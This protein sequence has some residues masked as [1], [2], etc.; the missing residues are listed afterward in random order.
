MDHLRMTRSTCPSYWRESSPVKPPCH[1]FETDYTTDKVDGSNR[2]SMGLN[3]GRGLFP[4][5]LGLT[6]S[7]AMERLHLATVEVEH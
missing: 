1:G 5:T 3:L 6:G 4:E 7:N 2:G